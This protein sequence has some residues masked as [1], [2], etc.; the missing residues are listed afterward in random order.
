MVG[1]PSESRE[2]S[3]LT[4]SLDTPLLGGGPPASSSSVVTTPAVLPGLNQNDSTL[5]GIGVGLADALVPGVWARNWNE[6]SVVDRSINIGLDALILIPLAGPAVRVGARSAVGAIRN[7]FRAG[8]GAEV[9]RLAERGAIML[10]D[11]IKASDD[12]LVRRGAE[13]L[14]EAALR[15]KSGTNLVRNR[16]REIVDN[17]TALSNA[18]NLIASEE[19]AVALGHSANRVGAAASR[20]D[21]LGTADDIGAF[22]AALT[23]TQNRIRRD[24][25]LSRIRRRTD[26][27]QARFEERFRL[28]GEPGA[29]PVAPP[30]ASPVAPPGASPVRRPSRLAESARIRRG[31]IERR[32]GARAEKV[33]PIV[34]PRLGGDPELDPE[35]VEPRPG[36]VTQPRTGTSTSPLDE[37]LDELGEPAVAP[38]TATSP[39]TTTLEEP[40]LELDPLAN[41]LPAPATK[42]ATTTV[43]EEEA[44]AQ[45]QTEPVRPVPTPT[46]RVAAPRAATPVSRAPTKPPPGESRRRG[47]GAP[48]ALP[49]SG[50]LIRNLPL[51]QHARVLRWE[52][53]A[54][55]ATFDLV[56]DGKPRFTRNKAPTGKTPRQSLRVIGTSTTRPPPRKFKLGFATVDLEDLGIVFRLADDR[57]KNQT[58]PRVRR[59]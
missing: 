21:A 19:G 16:I 17:S 13:L 48:P 22:E 27:Q 44:L 18:R 45:P 26:I 4:L 56:A 54:F 41:P 34:A 59:P 37:E 32:E 50:K 47:R 29:S 36:T 43:L 33:V 3:D 49:R 6:L 15:L 39:A 9:A 25:Y 57:M 40:A 24:I 7:A 8:A 38:S 55:V 1:P 35:L 2:P 58:F 42:A 51:G 14:N 31:R 30:G 20:L 5:T 53:G 11:G 52:Q 46:P 28:G 10:T 12:V 23:A